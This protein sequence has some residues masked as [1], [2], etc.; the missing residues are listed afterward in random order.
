MWWQ[1]DQ[2]V[3]QGETEK[4]SPGKVCKKCGSIEPQMA[5]RKEQ[6]ESQLKCGKHSAQLELTRL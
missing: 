6:M 4:L 5:S 3:E 1:E 2:E